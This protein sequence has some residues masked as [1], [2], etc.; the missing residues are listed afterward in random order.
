MFCVREYL[1]GMSCW[2]GIWRKMEIDQWEAGYVSP[3]AGLA[4]GL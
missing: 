1:G 4:I 3:A 2:Q